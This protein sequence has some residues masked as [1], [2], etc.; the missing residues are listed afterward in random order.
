M[1]LPDDTPD[2]DSAGLLAEV[3]A[4]D[5]SP[6]LTVTELSG[7]LKRTIET[8]F[9]RV[10]VRGEISGFK[11]HASGHCYFTVKDD[12]AC[13]DAVIWRSSAGVMAF[14]P[15]DGAEVIATGK[16]TTYPGRSRYQIVIDRLELA[17]EGALMALLERR[18]KALA[19]EGLFDAAR[20]RSLP[21]LPR[22]IG[23]VT[24]LDGAAI[25]DI[26]NVLGRRYRN[27]QLVIR[28]VRVQ[29]EGAAI[30]I[31]RGLKAIGRVPGVDVV[32]VGR[33][34]GSIE[35]LW[36]FNEE[37][38]ARAIAQ[39][40]IPVIAAVGHETDVTI[41]DFVADVRAPTPSAAAEIVVKAKDEFCNRINRLED[42]LGAVVRARVQR[43]GRRVDLLSAR[44]ALAGFPARVA[45]RGRHTAEVSHALARAVRLRVVSHERRLQILRRQLD[46]LDLGRRLAAIRTR[47]VSSDGR[48]SSAINRRRHRADNQLRESAARLESL[49][50]LAV[51]GR[52]Y[53]VCW[54]ADRTAIIREASATK[55]GDL[56]RVTLAKGELECDVRNTKM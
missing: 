35:D 56:V 13:I 51:L 38:V 22:R 21:A 6:P 40:P 36:A 20:K 15:E 24:S 37:I 25:R 1:D 27:L 23:V 8:A 39:A 33:G 34:G 44:P 2:L 10:R 7:A 26:I 42:R 54:N 30:E 46:T 49:S 28:P 47:L 45:L 31:A 12:A 14:K 17:G 43:L 52:G 9:D 41:A 18:R 19:G 50:P 53:A 32:I 16:L 11:R 3:A 5:N 4:G 55:A 29:G 48:L